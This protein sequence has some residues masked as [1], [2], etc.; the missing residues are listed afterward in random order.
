MA[1][2]NRMTVCNDTFSGLRLIVW[3]MVT[4]EA[5]ELLGRPGGGKG[6]KVNLVVVYKPISTGKWET[7]PPMPSDTLSEV[8]TLFIGLRVSAKNQNHRDNRPFVW[9]IGDSRD[10]IIGIGGRYNNRLVGRL[11]CPHAGCWVI[12]SRHSVIDGQINGDTVGYQVATASPPATAHGRRKAAKAK[13]RSPP[14]KNR[15]FKS[16]KD[17]PGK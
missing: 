9:H 10:S 8:P 4:A 7:A 12:A 6:I 17:L 15:R 16:I 1:L 11:Q 3:V 13:V 5:S 2:F 14:R